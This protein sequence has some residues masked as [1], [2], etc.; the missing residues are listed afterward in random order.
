ME[1]ESVAG[2]VFCRPRPVTEQS[3]LNSRRIFLVAA[4]LVG[5]AIVLTLLT[6]EAAAKGDSDFVGRLGIA[7][8]LLAWAAIIPYSWMFRIEARRRMQ[9]AAP[10]QIRATVA[11]AGDGVSTRGLL[12]LDQGSLVFHGEAFDFRLP[13]QCFS[14]PLRAKDFFGLSLR[15]YRL[16]LPKA[17]G[18]ALVSLRHESSNLALLEELLAAVSTGSNPVYPPLYRAQLVGANQKRKP[19]R[20]IVGLFASMIVTLIFGS[21]F[22]TETSVTILSRV[23]ASWPAFVLGLV[24]TAVVYV[25]A[26]SSATSGERAFRKLQARYDTF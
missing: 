17:F 24:I 3:G 14:R 18:P 5:A 20:W 13:A 19:D 2:V 7:M 16:T 8:L 22:A 15:A 4:S 9:E 12:T 1:T 25:D 26:R 23:R 11:W 6:R 21:F 10:L